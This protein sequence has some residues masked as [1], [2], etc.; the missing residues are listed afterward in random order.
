ME[1]NALYILFG[2]ERAHEYKLRYIIVKSH[3]TFDGKRSVTIDIDVEENEE[4]FKN[5]L[6]GKILKIR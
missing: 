5:F 1:K 6:V 2:V 4:P 3:G